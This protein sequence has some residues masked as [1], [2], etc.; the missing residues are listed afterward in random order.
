MPDYKLKFSEDSIEESRQSTINEIL[1]FIGIMDG[2]PLAVVTLSDN[3]SE[4][5]DT[6]GDIDYQDQ[7][8]RQIVSQ[9][10]DGVT[11]TLLIRNHQGFPLA[12]AALHDT[13]GWQGIGIDKRLRFEVARM[14]Q[15]DETEFM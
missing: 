15:N 8:G 10:S 9:V 5:W 12:L 2:R 4:L 7:F 3:Q 1:Q 11:E 6:E 14:F 13:D